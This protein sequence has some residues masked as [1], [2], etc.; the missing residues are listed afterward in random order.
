MPEEKR[1]KKVAPLTRDQEQAIRK[2]IFRTAHGAITDWSTFKWHRTNGVPDTHVPHSSQ[3]F[4]ISV[5]GTVASTQGA[6]VRKT[7]SCLLKDDRFARAV[8]SYEAELPLELESDSRDLLNE[9]GGTQSHLDGVLRLNGLSVVI[10]SKLTE[11]LGRCSQATGRYCSGIYG[12]G[13]DLKLGRTDVSC[14]LEYQD[15]QRT[16][17]L[18]WKIMKEISREGAYRVGEPCAFAGLGY[19]VMRN[20]AAAA[21]LAGDASNWRVIF[22]YPQ[23]YDSTTDEAIALVRNKL[24]VQHQHRVLVL[25]YINFARELMCST[26]EIAHDLGIHMAIRLGIE[27]AESDRVPGRLSD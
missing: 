25:D 21:K 19:Q 16:P 15:R 11:Q 27:P 10:E 5:W 26:N 17:R 22:A 6:V 23:S 14:R 24:A 1:E 12:P 9:F 18:Y 2:N 7:L 3:A 20:I 8:E 13:S 4:C